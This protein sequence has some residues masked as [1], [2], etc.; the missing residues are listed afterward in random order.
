MYL[1]KTYPFK[2]SLKDHT[3]NLLGQLEVLK[4]YYG[5]RI[6]VNWDLLRLACI[7]HDLGKVNRVFQKKLRGEN[8]RE[9]G[10]N[11]PHAYLSIL[12]INPEK[13]M[14]EYG[15][16]LD[17]LVIL[18]N[19]VAYHHKRLALDEEMLENI[20]AYIKYLRE[21][22]GDF[23]YWGWENLGEDIND[24]SLEIV[25]K[26]GLAGL[27]K[28]LVPNYIITKG[29][30]NKI[31]Y[32]AS[33]HYRIEYPSNFLLEGMENLKKKWGENASF[34]KLQKYMIDHREENVIAIGETGY[35]KTEAG[36]LWIGDNKGFFTLPLKS[37]INQT[38]ERIRK[39]IVEEDIGT[40]LGLLHS[41]S[42]GE[43]LVRNDNILDRELLDYQEITN[44]LSMPLTICTI[45]Q[46]FDFVYK[47]V[48]F[49]RKLA[50]LS[51][52]KIV[53]DEIQMY[54]SD[55]VA[56]I[57]IALDQVSK[58]GGKFAIITATFPPFIRD[59]LIEKNINFKMP[60]AFLYNDRIRHSLEIKEETIN[61]E[62]IYSKFKDQKDQKV[63]VIVNTVKKLR[64]LYEDLVENYG[65]GEEVKLFHSGFIRRDRMEKEREIVAFGQGEV[66]AS[67][68]WITTQVAEASLDID[69]DILI[70]E[71]SDLSSLFQRMGRCYRK[72]ELDRKSNIYIF[73]GGREETSG[74]GYVYDRDI[75]K[76]SKEA[77]RS[78]GDGKITEEEKIGLIN[79]VYSTKSLKG[80]KYYKEII[81]TIAYIN[82]I[83]YDEFKRKDVVKYFR[84]INSI[85]VIPRPIYEEN[86]GEIGS[87]MDI[88]SDQGKKSMDKDELYLARKKARLGL[89]KY[90]LAIQYYLIK[91]DRLD[92]VR[93]NKYDSI[94]IYDC[95][96]SSE[97]GIRHL[98][99]SEGKDEMFF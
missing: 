57:I 64:E 77:L 50:S 95:E 88:L 97:E 30:L 51:Y 34:N 46:I 21:D 72:R 13:L 96:Y 92:L 49:E 76:M 43:Y 44:E 62:F 2:E 6:R 65:L 67:G 28:K 5:D 12:F 26:S 19:V 91:E 7:Y 74:I 55:L 68:I 99:E 31:D 56:Y 80:S 52:S 93:I 94:S 58:L 79:K 47:Y 1:A 14:E 78:R 63:L 39:N 81:K 98:E 85:N 16:S 27:P 40:R 4:T 9:E 15:L 82:S 38:Y 59:L 33:G 32:A 22:V 69:F 66:R 71:L 84:N 61:A 3:E 87:F 8:L 18:I 23:N 36:L 73:D 10:P 24:L 70:T 86:I 41:D 25:S 75:Y 45:D 42:L 53:I 11:I 17:D 83:N 37:A 35:G 54:S 90:K 60:E 20:K 29:L 48:G 89:E